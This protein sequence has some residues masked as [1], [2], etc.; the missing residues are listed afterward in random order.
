MRKAIRALG[1]LAW[2]A[3]SS[4]ATALIQS[5]MMQCLWRW[6]LAREYGHGP[7]MG[8]WFGV[9][10]ITG[11]VVHKSTRNGTKTEDDKSID[12]L[13]WDGVRETVGLWIGCV[14][15]LGIAWCV[16]AFMGWGP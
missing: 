15:I 14:I 13:V 10:T 6:F 1:I 5:W 4:L 2:I 11:F 3:V 12:E 7:S 16:G 8:A 9:A